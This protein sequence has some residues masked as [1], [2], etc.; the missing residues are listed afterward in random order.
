MT[1]MKQIK[2]LHQIEYGYLCNLLQQ[3]KTDTVAP[4]KQN[5]TGRVQASV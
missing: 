4:L 5:V 2:F 3:Q 1:K